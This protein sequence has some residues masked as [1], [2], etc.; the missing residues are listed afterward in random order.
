MSSGL[1]QY[2]TIAASADGRRLVASVASPRAGLWSVPILDRLV[3]AGEV[4]PYRLP[5]VRALAPRVRGTSL[6]YLSALGTGDGLW[7][8]KDGQSLEI[9]RGS[10]GALLEP[11]AVSP[12]GLRV[13]VALRKGGKRYP[14]GR[15]SGWR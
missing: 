7:R 14:D 15:G 8:F 12:D 1:E 10:Q 9:W 2:T 6:F 13:V 3:V 11:P 5:A 4:Q